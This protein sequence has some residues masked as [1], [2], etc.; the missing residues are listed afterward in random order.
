MNFR[1]LG[2]GNAQIS[3]LGHSACVVE[4]DT[5][6]RLLIDCGFGVSQ[7]YRKQYQCLPDA[8]FITHVHLD[9]IGGL[10]QLMF[11]NWF[12]EKK[13]I[14]L[15]V[16]VTIISLL[17]QRIASLDNQLAE[18]GTNFWEAFQLIPVSDSFWLQGFKFQVFQ[19]RHHAPAFCFGLSL[20]GR[21]LFTG[22]TKPI[23]ETIIHH[24]SQ[25]EIIFH[26]LSLQK[27]PSHSYLDEVMTYPEAVL[28][29]IWFY[30]LDSAESIA[31]LRKMGLNCVAPNQ[32]FNLYGN[33]VHFWLQ[34]NVSSEQILREPCTD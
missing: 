2:C 15:F 10:E 26:D 33:D 31:K 32:L 27:Q 14:K 23:P 18:G 4:F 30:H 9:H 7:Q 12:G 11:S 5:D 19:N 6:R 17:H 24:A 29:R 20:P 21:F 34:S 13:L 28:K 1:F 22:D 8:I 3:E 16:P 25:G